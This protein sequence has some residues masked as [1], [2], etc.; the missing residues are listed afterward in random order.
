MRS[1]YRTLL[2]RLRR[3]CIPQ[4]SVSGV[5]LEQFLIDPQ[6]YNKNIRHELEYHI[7]EAF[8]DKYPTN[9]RLFRA[10]I[11]GNKVVDALSDPTSPEIIRIVV[12]NRK[13]Q[14]NK[15]I[16][17][18][19]YLANKQE[20]QEE[21]EKGISGRDIK[22]KLAKI[23]PPTPRVDIFG[24]LQPWE[25]RE[26]IDEELAKSRHL[27][28][29]HL[30]AYLRE[31]QRR[32]ELPIPQNLIEGVKPPEYRRKFTVA[33]ANKTKYLK[34]AYDMEYIDSV[35]KPSVAYDI[36]MDK[37]KSMQKYLEAGPY[38]VKI[39]QN[40]SGPFPATYTKLPYNR[41]R[42]M[43]K[44]ALDI[45]KAARAVRIKDV[46][47][48]SSQEQTNSDGSVHIDKCG[49]IFPRPYYAKLVEGEAL[50]EHLR[51]GKPM[52]RCSKEWEWFLN[53][54]TTALKQEVQECRNVFKEQRKVCLEERP[55][56]Q[57]KMNTWYDR[58]V[59]RYEKLMKKLEVDGVFKHSEIVNGNVKT[60]SYF[61]KLRRH[62]QGLPVNEGVGMGKKLGDYVGGF[63]WGKS[64]K[65]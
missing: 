7:K 52:Q 40:M 62:E 13:E 24:K 44:L 47:E 49:D 21:M 60:D 35:I 16:Q 58:N 48:G 15:Q 45:K 22:R 6:Q 3:I 12:E 20:V 17:R 61:T 51:T 46:W 57:E 59:E 11:H 28:R 8:R 34:Q 9:E 55:I 39:A 19:N 32:N 26:V 2:R 65:K 29:Q 33:L 30:N 27:A 50:W 54:T 63:D 42:V 38:K 18:A 31:K 5:E 14:F 36:N 41:P 4:S 53:T 25:Q 43:K 23:T 1:L 10:L 37:I 64:M 56:L